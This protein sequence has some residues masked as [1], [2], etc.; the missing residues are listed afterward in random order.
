MPRGGRACGQPPALALLQ[1]ICL[2]IV[3]VP[4]ET[5]LKLAALGG[6]LGPVGHEAVMRGSLRAR[7]MRALASEA[8]GEGSEF[9]GF[10]WR[11]AWG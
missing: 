11:W 1:A 4:A 7:G 3:A 5:T 10:V 9:C 6:L 2:A 8:L